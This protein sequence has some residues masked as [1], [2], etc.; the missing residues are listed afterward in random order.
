LPFDQNEWK[1]ADTHDPN[2][3]R[4][5]MVR[6]LARNFRLEGMT[7]QELL[8]LLGPPEWTSEPYSQKPDLSASAKVFWYFLGNRV[9]FA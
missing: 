6:A 8:D 9:S 5:Q 2:S 3:V 4:G 1:T 7:R